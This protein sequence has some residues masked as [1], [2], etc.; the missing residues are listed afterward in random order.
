MSPRFS[1]FLQ[2]YVTYIS[3]LQSILS[4]IYIYLYVQAS[5]RGKGRCIVESL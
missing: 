5:D 3:K 2:K 4:L 1:L